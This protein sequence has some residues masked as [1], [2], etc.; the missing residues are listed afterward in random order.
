MLP[1]FVITGYL[2]SGK[3]TLLINSART[4]FKNKRVAVIVNEFGEVGVDGKVLQNAYSEVIELPEGCI[5]CTLHA[6]FEKSL[7]EI[8]QKYDPEVLLVET[9]GTSEPF[10]VILSLQNL[11]CTVEGIICVIDSANF[12]RYQEESTALHQI[13]GS[14]IIVLNKTDL[15]EGEVVKE[16]ESRVRRIWE[17]YRVKNFFTGEPIFDRV[18]VYRATYGNVPEEVFSG[19]YSLGELVAIAGEHNHHPSHAR[20]VIELTGGVGEAEKILAGLG[21]EVVRAKGIVVEGDS[22]YLI[23]YSFGYKDIAPIE[24]YEGKS[25]LVLI[26]RG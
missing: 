7:A 5:C 19:V 3:T 14:N 8:R 17:K 16:L 21:D 25:F 9:S 11:S 26:K 13:G 10:P 20:E 15:A 24:G 22:A 4:H 12:P 23:N 6:E 2:G 1:S 18:S